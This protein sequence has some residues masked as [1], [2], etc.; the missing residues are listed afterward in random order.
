MALAALELGQGQFEAARNCA[1]D[2]FSKSLSYLGTL[3]LP[4]LVEA[5]VSSGDRETAA[6]ALRALPERALASGTDHALGLLARHGPWS[7]RGRGQAA[8]P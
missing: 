7:Q 1:L 6:A 4:D 2:V 5:S 3:V 8:L